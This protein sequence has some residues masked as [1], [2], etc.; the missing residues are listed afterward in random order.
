MPRQ[1]PLN[2][3]AADDF[4]PHEIGWVTSQGVIKVENP[5]GL[6]KSVVQVRALDHVQAGQR[7]RFIETSDQPDIH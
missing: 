1:T 6:P 5:K 4:R 2:L 7:G 3:L